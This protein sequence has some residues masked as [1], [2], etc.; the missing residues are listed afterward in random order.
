MTSI[1]VKNGGLYNPRGG[2]EICIAL[3]I[4]IPTDTA[5]LSHVWYTRNILLQFYLLTKEFGFP[6]MYC[7]LF[8]M[9]NKYITVPKFY[10]HFFPYLVELYGINIG[11]RYL[12][13]NKLGLR[14]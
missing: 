3:W 9:D 8:E 13:I 10:S 1:V 2:K 5:R 4:K 6:L 11:G 12:T 14:K 7:R